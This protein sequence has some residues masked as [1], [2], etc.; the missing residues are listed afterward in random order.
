MLYATTRN[1]K[2]T[3]TAHRALTEARA[4]DGGFYIPFRHPVFSRED[5][6]AMKEKNL[7]EV[8]A[9][10][11]GLL[12][13]T[14]ITGTELG[15]VIGRH[16]VKLQKIDRRTLSCERWRN[17][18][19]SFQG[20]VRELS[21]KLRAEKPLAGEKPYGPW[22][23]VGMGIASLFGTF[24]ELSRLVEP[25]KKIDVAAA[26]DDLYSVLS[27][28][29]ARDWGL[30]IGTVVAACQ[31]STGLWDLLHSGQMRTDQPL[32]EGMEL[33]ICFCGGQR[34]AQ[35]FGEA[36]GKG[37]PFIPMD[38][39]L[40]RLREALSVSVISKKRVLGTISGAWSSHGCLFSPDS[41]LAYAGLLDYRAGSG[42]G[43]W[44]MILSDRGPSMDP[45]LTARV[46]GVSEKQAGEI[47]NSI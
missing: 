2:E 39:T 21:L 15:F 23:E 47:L 27:A 37:R 9:E 1:Q 42:T 33:L 19:W 28:L 3:C 36:L 30:P 35:R 41:A 29:Y 4:S 26:C 18:G 25:E 46:L 44:G 32:P 14:R 11:L 13:G 22:A 38:L 12:F 6:Q 17:P 31:E 10:L 40:Q 5:L 34:E 16:P 8:S 7:R 24:S 20:S 45:A 43:G